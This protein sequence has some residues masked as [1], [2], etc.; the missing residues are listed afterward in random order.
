MKF[1][2]LDT[3]TYSIIYSVKVTFSMQ[4]ND[5]ATTVNNQTICDSLPDRLNYF[6]EFLLTYI[7][8]SSKRKIRAKSI[9][10]RIVCHQTLALALYV[11]SNIA[12]ELS[13]PWPS[14]CCSKNMFRVYSSKSY[15]NGLP[16]ITC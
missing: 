10:I 7:P 14:T 5:F 8:S 4:R 16:P 3:S 11:F 13:F 9:H 12:G 15:C 2:S 1:K 6:L